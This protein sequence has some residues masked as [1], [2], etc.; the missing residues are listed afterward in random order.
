MKD[1]ME[2][3]GFRGGNWQ[4]MRENQEGLSDG[5]YNGG[6]QLPGVSGSSFSKK[7]L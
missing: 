2:R 4:L 5:Y 6:C 1:T 7:K 3:H